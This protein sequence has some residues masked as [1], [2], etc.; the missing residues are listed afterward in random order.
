MIGKAMAA[1]VLVLAAMTVSGCME[2]NVHAIETG[3]EFQ[4]EQNLNSIRQGIISWQTQPGNGDKKLPDNF[5]DYP[6]VN[7]DIQMAP[8]GHYNGYIY[9]IFLSEDGNHY[10]LFAYPV[11]RGMNGE[12]SYFLNENGAPKSHDFGDKNDNSK[13]N[14]DS[15]LAF[16]SSMG[17]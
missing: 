14:Y 13:W 1:A 2:Q 17:G 16:F 8:N 12:S 3:K 7:R 9:R 4:V 11:Q 10:L 15:V 6:A 5:A